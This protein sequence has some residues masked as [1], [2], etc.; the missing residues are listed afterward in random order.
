[1]YNGRIL[2]CLEEIDQQIYIIKLDKVPPRYEEY[3]TIELY[4]KHWNP[5]ENEDE[6]DKII[7]VY[8]SGFADTYII[9]LHLNMELRYL[10]LNVENDD[11]VDLEKVIKES[12]KVDYCILSYEALR[13]LA[14]LINN[15][16]LS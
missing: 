2:A 6:E 5:Q 16:S 14:K 11:Y 4:L 1:V 12:S 3:E 7:I 8:N 13:Y 9:N 10:V 15:L